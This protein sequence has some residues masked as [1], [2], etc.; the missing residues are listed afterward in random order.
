MLI[1]NMH[2]YVPISGV[3]ALPADATPFLGRMWLGPDGKV[4][5][6][7]YVA[8]LA[9]VDAI[10]YGIPVS[11]DGYTGDFEMDFKLNSDGIPT[12]TNVLFSS[13]QGAT[14]CF[15]L[16]RTTSAIQQPQVVFRNLSTTVAASLSPGNYSDAAWHRINVVKQG[17]SAVVKIDG[18]T[19]SSLNLS[20]WDPEVSTA[21]RFLGNSA[22]GTSTRVLICDYT[23]K[24]GSS[25]IINSPMDDGSG[26]VVRDISGNG[27]NAT[28]TDGSPTGVWAVDWVP[29]EF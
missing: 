16:Q 19:F 6:A 14:K 22:S 1:K 3:G 24:R 18:T 28:I 11:S 17:A 21:H 9:G 27:N 23:L 8:K 5:R 2:K 12:A 15:A 20:A 26:T 13:I 10:L 25:L 7:R 4:Y 29:I